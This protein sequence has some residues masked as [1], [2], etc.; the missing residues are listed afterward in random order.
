MTLCSGQ[1]K[2]GTIEYSTRFKVT[3]ELKKYLG[4][5]ELTKLCCNMQCC[6]SALGL[7]IHAGSSLQQPATAGRLPL[8]AA[9]WRLCACAAAAGPWA[10]AAALAAA[11]ESSL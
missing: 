9:K 6:L 8:R 1:M 2:R 10:R 3:T 4:C 5:T 7:L 11:F